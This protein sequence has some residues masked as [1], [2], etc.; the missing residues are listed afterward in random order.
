[1]DAS[2]SLSLLTLEKRPDFVETDFIRDIVQRA[3]MYLHADYPVHFSGPPGA[4]KT[5]LAMHVAAQLQQDVVL[6]HGDD[7]FGSADLVGDSSGYRCTELVDNYVHSVVK[8]ETRLTR[9]WVDNRVT[10][11]CRH[12]YTLIYDEFTR[13]R[14]ETNNVLLPVLEEKLLALPGAPQ[15]ERY[16]PV[17]P[18]FAAIFT[19]NP[20]EYAGIHRSQDALTDRMITIRLDHHD[21]DTEIAIT[22]A[23]SGIGIEEASALVAMV[24]EFR[25]L[26]GTMR[27]TIR[28]CVMLARLVA[29]R[30]GRVDP[31]DALFRQ[32]C[33]DV[34]NIDL[35]RGTSRSSDD[36]SPRYALESIDRI[37]D[38][39]CVACPADG[40]STE[41]S[42]A[43]GSRIATDD[44]GDGCAEAGCAVAGAT[45]DRFEVVT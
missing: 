33:R 12:G 21:A 38:T 27:P 45:D 15:A 2:D 13:S 25:K 3:L 31:A 7:G 4:G 34:V 22:R 37:I 32:I 10:W 8:K 17:H 23:K 41:S 36:A 5:A 44:I 35:A 9:H 26:S 1:M 19:S 29:V 11:A 42:I 14:P 43:A 24:R 39:C 20:E 6:I 16:L 30:G 28:A 40:I 18:N